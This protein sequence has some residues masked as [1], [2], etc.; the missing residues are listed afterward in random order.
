MLR[1]PLFAL[2]TYIATR[3]RLDGNVVDERMAELFRRVGLRM[4]VTELV[5]LGS[6]KLET[7]PRRA[8][9]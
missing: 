2:V 6:M 8:P 1:M 4:P 3:L 7:Q 9:R 5:Q